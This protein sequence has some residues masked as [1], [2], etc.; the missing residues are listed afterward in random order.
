MTR[1]ETVSGLR[2]PATGS[3]DVLQQNMGMDSNPYQSPLESADRPRVTLRQARLRLLFVSLSL[4]IAYHVVMYL[5]L[6]ALGVKFSYVMAITAA[7]A[8]VFIR[9]LGHNWAAMEH[10]YA[11]TV[12][13]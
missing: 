2:M 4:M 3:G 10:T 1:Q 5:A 11:T 8:L 13:E 6:P 9:K 7:G 12:R